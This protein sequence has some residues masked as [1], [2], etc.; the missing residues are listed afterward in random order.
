MRPERVS[1]KVKRLPPGLPNAGFRFINHKIIRVVDDL[2]LKS[3]PPF[4][5]PPGLQKA[6]HVQMAS[7]GLS[8]RVPLPSRSSTGAF[9]PILIRRSTC[10]STILRATH[11]IRA[12]RGM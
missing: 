1:E 11:C 8:R 10:R 7:L 4:G 9:S 12:E 5:D 3:L 6:V 2:G